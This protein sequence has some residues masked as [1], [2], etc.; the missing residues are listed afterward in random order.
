MKA[1]GSMPAGAVQAFIDVITNYFEHLTGE[2][3]KMGVPYVRDSSEDGVQYTAVISISGSHKGAILLTTTGEML[4]EL[5]SIILGEKIDPDDY[6][7][8]VGEITNTIA[9]NM[10]RTLG[11]H[12]NI[13]VPLIFTR[14]LYE[15]TRNLQQPVFMI[16]IQWRTYKALVAIGLD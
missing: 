2:S 9:G 11:S 6:E 1:H 5:G 14:G 13:S 10:R 8:L 3:A 16:P 7:D 15:L 12:Y 4:D